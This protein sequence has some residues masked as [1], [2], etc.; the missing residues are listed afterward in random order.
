MCTIIEGS[1]PNATSAALPL[2][3]SGYD[4]MHFV[5]LFATGRGKPRRNNDAIFEHKVEKNSN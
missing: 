2:V 3:H 5:G 1:L 4:C